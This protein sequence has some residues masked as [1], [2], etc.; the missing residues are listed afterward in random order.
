MKYKSEKLVSN[1]FKNKN[2]SY[3]EW[4]LYN[5]I[6]KFHI[7]KSTVLMQQFYFF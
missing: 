4:E 1:Y 3:M 6:I 2:G 5:K 7:K